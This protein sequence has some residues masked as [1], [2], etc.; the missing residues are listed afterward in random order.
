MPVIG[1]TQALATEPFLH[2]AT[3]GRNQEEELTTKA[4]THQGCCT[5]D[6]RSPLMNRNHC[7]FVHIFH[8]FFARNEEIECYSQAGVSPENSCTPPPQKG[9]IMSDTKP[10]FLSKTIITS[11]VAFLVAIAT[12]AGLVDLETGTKLESLLV[13]LLFIFLRMGDKELA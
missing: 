4:P 2:D 5:G 13:P 7:G 3:S 10:W 6:R 1:R 12:S 11:G 9:V 8:V